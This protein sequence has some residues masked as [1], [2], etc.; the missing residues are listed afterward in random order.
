MKILN[1]G[2]GAVGLGL[3]SC[4][5]KA[6][7]EVHIIGRQKTTTCLKSDGLLRKGIFGE[8]HASPRNFFCYNSLDEVHS[9]N[10]DYILVSTKSFDSDYA[11]QDLQNHPQLILPTLEM[12]F[13]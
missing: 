7:A 9:S 10:F 11:A 8:F 6:G 4:L 2:A 1:Y 12:T 3:D 13:H 5:I